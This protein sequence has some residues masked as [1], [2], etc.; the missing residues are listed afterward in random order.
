VPVASSNIFNGFQTNHQRLIVLF[1]TKR[2]IERKLYDAA[3]LLKV[4]IITFLNG[5]RN[6][7]ISLR[8]AFGD[9]EERMM[10]ISQLMLKC[11]E[12][13]EKVPLFER[14]R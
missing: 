5:A 7:A 4:K 11:E 12:N 6:Q 10:E 8:P 14:F 2:A 1:H 13:V 9:K 3:V